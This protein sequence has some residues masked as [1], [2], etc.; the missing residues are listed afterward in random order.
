MGRA[1]SHARD[2]SG[3]HRRHRVARGIPTTKT[4]AD[5][6]FLVIASPH[7]PH[8]QSILPLNW[9]VLRVGLYPRNAKSATRGAAIGQVAVGLVHDD[10]ALEEAGIVVAVRFANV[11]SISKWSCPRLVQQRGEPGAPGEMNYS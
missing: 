9:Q 6:I 10:F 3:T 5:V 1:R 8:S 4:R 11:N 2:L 7:G